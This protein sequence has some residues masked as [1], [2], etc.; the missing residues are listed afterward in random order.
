MP[1]QFDGATCKNADRRFFYSY[2]GPNSYFQLENLMLH[3]NH[4]CRNIEITGL[5]QRL[6]WA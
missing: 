4:E 5:S 3:Q 1:C 2:S 6:T